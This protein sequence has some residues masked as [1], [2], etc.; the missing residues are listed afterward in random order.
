MDLVCG[1]CEG[2]GECEQLS[3]HEALLEEAIMGF[4]NEL[5]NALTPQEVMGPTARGIV[6]DGTDPAVFERNTVN[7]QTMINYLVSGSGGGTSSSLR[8]ATTSALRLSRRT[9]EREQTSWWT[10]EWRS[11]SCRGRCS[12]R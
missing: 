8:G 10:G 5:I 1:N 6:A 9:L 11:C 3:R 12:F 4:G 7:L 2:S